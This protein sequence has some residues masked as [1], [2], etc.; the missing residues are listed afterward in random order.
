[1]ERAAERPGVVQLLRVD[2]SGGAAGQI[3]DV[4]GSGAARGETQLVDRGQDGDRVCR[5]DLADLQVGAGGNVDIAAPISFGDVGETSG[6]MCEDNA[7]RQAQAQHERVLVGRDVEK[8][9]ELVPEDVEPFRKPSG[10]GV[11][12]DLIPHVERVLLALGDFLG[13]EL[14]AGSNGPIL[15]FVMDRHRV[16]PVGICRG[17]CRGASR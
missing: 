10:R 14:S 9:V 4:V 1:M 8:A 6:L 12:G 3:T 17:R 15:R 16:G 11:G 13:G 7:A 2:P 5:A